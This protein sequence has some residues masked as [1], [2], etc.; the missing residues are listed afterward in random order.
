MKM[1]NFTRPSMSTS[2]PVHTVRVSSRARRP[3]LRLPPGKDL[4]VVLPVG[5][6][7]ALVPVILTRHRDWID[8][9]LA[10]RADEPAREPDV[11]PFCFPIRGGAEVVALRLT[12]RN[13][14]LHGEAPEL[15]KLGSEEGVPRRELVLPAFAGDLRTRPDKA[16]V[17]LREA[18]RKEAAELL[19]GLLAALAD[20]F[21][22]SCAPGRMRFQKSRWGSCS[23]QGII[24]LNTALLFLPDRLIRHVLLHELCHTKEMNH[25]ERYWKLLF[26]VEPK[27]LEYDQELRRARARWVPGWAW[28]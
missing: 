25:S 8:R 10:R 13:A 2:L 24:N 5:A 12:G 28:G 15:F 14:L 21:G 27:A 1:L 19:F 9:V 17:L 23:V 6:D 7:P 18:L 26:A 22:F 20:E 11:F 4:E 16:F 3:L